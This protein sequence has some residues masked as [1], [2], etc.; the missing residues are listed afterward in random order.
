MEEWK[1]RCTGWKRNCLEAERKYKLLAALAEKKLEGMKDATKQIAGYSKTKLPEIEVD[2][3]D[4]VFAKLSNAKKPAPVKLHV[5]K[6]AFRLGDDLN[7][8]KSFGE[9]DQGRRYG[10][11]LPPQ[12]PQ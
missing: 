8:P 11:K 10:V 7:P 12:H 9:R 6:K 3:A 4:A 5:K 1:K 2:E